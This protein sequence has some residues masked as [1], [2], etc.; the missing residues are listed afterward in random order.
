VQCETT[1]YEVDPLICRSCGAEMKV[2]SFITDRPVILEILGH[3]DGKGM[4]RGRAPPGLGGLEA[5]S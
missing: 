2:I 4:G 3:R 1:S 5:V